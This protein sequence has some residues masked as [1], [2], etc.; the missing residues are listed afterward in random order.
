MIYFRPFYRHQNWYNDEEKGNVSKD[1]FAEPLAVFNNT[2]VQERGTGLYDK[3]RILCWVLTS[4]DHY[5]T[6]AKAVKETWGKRCNILLFMSSTEG[7]LYFQHLNEKL[8]PLFKCNL[9]KS[10]PAIKLNVTEGRNGLWGKTRE[11]FRY[12]WE[13]YRD[14]VDWFFKADDDT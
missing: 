12:V 14:Q 11:A 3:I 1:T 5:E 6:R 8:D 7:N 9:D 13:T 10:L 4:P 2:L